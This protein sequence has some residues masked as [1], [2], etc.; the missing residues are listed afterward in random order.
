MYT[1]LQH[2]Y[3]DRDNIC[4]FTVMHTDPSTGVESALDLS[5]V[6]SIVL[7]LH[8]AASDGGDLTITNEDVSMTWDSAG[9]VT[10]K[11][12]GYALLARGEYPA[13]V[14][15]KDAGHAVR[16]QVLAHPNGDSRMTVRV[17]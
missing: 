13:T 5:P 14:I 2:V 3:K 9:R 11:L 4:D 15:I 16:G 1:L 10:M 6:Y 17:S 8:G 12:G 7:V